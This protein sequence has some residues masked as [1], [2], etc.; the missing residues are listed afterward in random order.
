MKMEDFVCGLVKNVNAFVR[1]KNRTRGKFY[2][3][4]FPFVC[5]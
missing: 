1:N 3:L 5:A 2:F 4:I